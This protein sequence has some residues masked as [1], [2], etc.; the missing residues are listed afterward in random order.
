MLLLQTATRGRS[1]GVAFPS[2]YINVWFSRKGGGEEEI[3]GIFFFIFCF[4]AGEKKR[5]IKLSAGRS[6][7]KNVSWGKHQMMRWFALIHKR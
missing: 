4:T 3:P 6:G 2:V 1:Y 7:G 5:S